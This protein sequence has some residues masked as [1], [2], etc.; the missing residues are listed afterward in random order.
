MRWGWSDVRDAGWVWR[1]AESGG[2]L[3]RIYE[4]EVLAMEVGEVGG[5]QYCVV[6]RF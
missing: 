4:V 1:K 5:K 6:T 3:L 2:R